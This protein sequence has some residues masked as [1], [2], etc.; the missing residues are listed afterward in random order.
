M[1]IYIDLKQEVNK[2]YDM[3]TAGCNGDTF[4]VVNL[5]ALQSRR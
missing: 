2:Y 1:Y 5:L 4:V 3:V